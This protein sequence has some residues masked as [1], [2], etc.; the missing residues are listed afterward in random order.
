MSKQG[1]TILIL[2]NKQ[3]T[4]IQFRLE[5]VAALVQAGYRV[6]VSAPQGDRWSEIEAVGATMISTPM[7]K[8]STDPIHDFRLM[9]TYRR[10]IKETEADLVL[11][12]TIKPNVYG[13]M[14]AASRRVPYIANIT[15]LGTA[16]EGHGAMQKLALL[17]YRIGF[18]KISRVFFQNAENRAF[19]EQHKLAL[20]KHALLPGSGVN[21]QKFRAMDYP[22][23]GA[24]NFAFISRIRKEKGIEQYIDTARAIK[25]THPN[26]QFHVCGYGDE[27]YETR[28]KQLHEEG[29]IVYHG[30]LKD[31]KP[32]LEQIHCV[33]HP[34]YYPE[35]MSNV[36]L[37][38]AACCRPIISTDRAGCRETIDHGVNG[39]LVREQDSADLI[40]KVETFLSLSYDERREM[41]LRGREKVARE[42]DRNLVVQAYLDAAAEFCKGDAQ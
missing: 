1:N 26:A 17:L 40:E 39:Y 31:V 22:A 10:L 32:V 36:L 18:R 13:G 33:V 23:D 3:T 24:V 27:Q 14:A 2:V 16:L 20:Q 5:V 37:E 15:G 9:M 42:F 38:S 30:F 41:G 6:Y 19:F 25:V 7:N 4:I 28:M 29:V 11:T 35:G 12:Y 34:T 8:D 21:L